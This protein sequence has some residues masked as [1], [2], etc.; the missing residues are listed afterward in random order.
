[1]ED[2]GLVFSIGNNPCYKAEELLLR[3]KKKGRDEE[4]L[5]K[6][7]CSLPTSSESDKVEE[8]RDANDILMWMTKNEIECCCPHLINRNVTKSEAKNDAATSPEPE[9]DDSF[10]EMVEDVTNLVSRAKRIVQ[11][12]S[13]NSNP[14]TQRNLSNTINIL[15]AYAKLGS[16][17]ESFRRCNALDLLLELLSSNVPH[18]R[19]SASEML[20]CLAMYDSASRS[21]V[22]LQLAQSSEGGA[23]SYENR[24]MLI[25]L[26]AETTET[27]ENVNPFLP[28]VIYKYNIELILMEDKYTCRFTNVTSNLVHNM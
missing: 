21:Y 3:R 2:G 10:Q 19:Q 15:C 28:Q 12:L 7:T 4:V 16:L 1:M 14:N 22:L 27:N 13:K 24:Q 25:D 8:L 23:C 5:V 26:F 6:W 18:I 9:T 17:A 11:K 20:R